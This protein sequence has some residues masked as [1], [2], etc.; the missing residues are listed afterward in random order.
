MIL[1]NFINFVQFFYKNYG[2]FIRNFVYWFI[3]FD[4]LM[5]N[6][7]QISFISL[8]CSSIHAV[9]FCYCWLVEPV[10]RMRSKKLG[11]LAHCPI[12]LIFWIPFSKPY[13]YNIQGLAFRPFSMLEIHAQHTPYF[14]CKGTFDVLLLCST[15]CRWICSIRGPIHNPLCDLS[16][17]PMCRIYLPVGLSK[18]GWLFSYLPQI[19][20]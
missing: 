9:F 1:T 14:L 3:Y 18:H 5:H 16:S 10:S 19:S 7:V 13:S 4:I 6:C 8:V 20:S 2:N 15:D 11:Q 17:I 12:P